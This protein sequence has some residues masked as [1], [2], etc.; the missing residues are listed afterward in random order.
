[1]DL[2]R[3]HHLAVEAMRARGLLPAFTPQALQEAEAARQAGPNRRFPDLV[4]QRLVKGALAGE[5]P[6]WSLQE[7]AEIARHCTLQEDNANRVERQVL[8]AAAGW[9]MQNRIGETFAAIVTG[10][11]PKATFVST[12]RPLV[13]G[14]LVRGFEGAD[15]GDALQVRLLAVDP[16]QGFIDFARA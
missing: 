2:S 4:T 9:L 14:R 15:V 11:S 3:L 13:E 8:K 12:S 7:L 5:A 10:A 1:M 16:E 6:P